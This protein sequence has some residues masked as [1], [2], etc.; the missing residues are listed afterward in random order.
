MAV[1]LCQAIKQGLRW[2]LLYCIDNFL[3]LR[4]L[5]YLLVFIE[6]HFSRTPVQGQKDYYPRDKK[7]RNPV[8]NHRLGDH[9]FTKILLHQSRVGLQV[10]GKAFFL[11]FVL[12][13]LIGPAI[14]ADDPFR[15]R[16]NGGPDERECID[17]GLSIVRVFISRVIHQCWYVDD[18]RNQEDKGQGPQTAEIKVDSNAPLDKGGGGCGKGIVEFGILCVFPGLGS[19]QDVTRHIV[20]GKVSWQSNVFV[21]GVGRRK[22]GSPWIAEAGKIPLLLWPG[23]VW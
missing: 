10:N 16:A 20:A 11:V 19:M 8:R 23:N 5:R 21:V 12:T 18:P 2:Y 4:D 3:S 6:T 9:S 15:R 13:E 7:E 17:C 1:I 14:L 22:G